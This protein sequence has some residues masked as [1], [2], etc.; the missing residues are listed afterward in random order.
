MSAQG[1]VKRQGSAVLNSAAHPDTGVSPTDI[2]RAIC[3]TIWR[4]KRSYQH[5]LNSANPHYLC[6]IEKI[7]EL[8]TPGIEAH[9]VTDG[10]AVEPRRRID[11]GAAFHVNPSDLSEA[12]IST[13]A[14]GLAGNQ[15]HPV[16]GRYLKGNTLDEEQC[17]G[18]F[19][20]SWEHGFLL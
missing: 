5:P 14:R 2:P 12:I 13:T 8:I 11:D 10:A 9:I 15:A 16:L 20:K 3:I 17:D 6:C 18:D 19:P 1:V 4:R 7:G